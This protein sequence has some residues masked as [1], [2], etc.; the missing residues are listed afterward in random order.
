MKTLSALYSLQ[1]SISKKIDEA[2]RQVE[3]WNDPADKKRLKA[4]RVVF[5]ELK[6][7]EMQ[8]R[9]ER[10]QKASLEL[11]KKLSKSGKAVF[12]RRKA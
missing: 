6:D 12:R 10:E 9:I 8:L 11:Y 5:K 7:T 4:L 1:N 3:L 2:K